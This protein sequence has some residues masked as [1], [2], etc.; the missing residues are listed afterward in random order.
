MRAKLLELIPEFDLIQDQ[1]L[2]EKTLGV[3]MKAMELGGWQPAD[4]DLIPFTLLIK[5][6]PASFLSHTRGVTQVACHAAKIVADRYGEHLTLNQDYLVAGALLHDIGKLLEYRREGN[7]YHK[8]AQG[9]LLRHPFSG[10]NLAFAG[11]LPDE[12]VHMI[13]VHAKE[14]DSGKRSPEAVIIHH[15]DF[16]NFEIFK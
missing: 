14:G 10:A 2:K 11:G 9:E 12:V 13:A 1:E 16:I 5:P 3:W 8:S 7:E 15:A 6:C 4:L